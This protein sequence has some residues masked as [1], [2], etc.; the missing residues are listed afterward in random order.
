MP[1]G[2]A[3]AIA[4]E[5]E[6]SVQFYS[7]AGIPVPAAVLLIAPARHRTLAARRQIRL[8]LAAIFHKMPLIPAIPIPLAPPARPC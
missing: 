6:N 8:K 4:A 5:F 7:I 3:Q 2:W 1:A